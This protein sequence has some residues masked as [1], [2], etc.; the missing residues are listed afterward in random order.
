MVAGISCLVHVRTLDRKNY[1]IQKVTPLP[2]AIVNERDDV[3]LKG[4]AVCDSP[5]AGP[6]FDV[7]C[8]YYQYKLKERTRQVYRNSKGKRRVRTVW[9]TRETR[10]EATGFYLRDGEHVIHINGDDADFRDN[11][12]D[13]DTVGGWRHCLEYF[14]F[15]ADIN[16][17]GSVSEGKKSLETYA[18]IPL[19]VTTK[20]REEFVKEA[21]RNEVWWRRGGFILS[22]L[23]LT[24][25]LSFFGMIEW[26]NW[27]V[28]AFRPLSGVRFVLGAVTATVVIG[29]YWCVFKYNSMV[30]YR[31][32]VENAWYQIDVDLSMR[33]DLIPR[34]VECVKGVMAHER[35]LTEELS[36]L[37]SQAKTS[38][39]NKLNLEGKVAT[40]VDRTIARVESY[41]DLK[42]Q[43]ATFQLTR[44]L[45][46]IEEKIAHGRTIYNESVREYNN[47]IRMFPQVVIANL[48][49]F[50]EHTFFSTPEEKTQS[51][52]IDM[53]GMG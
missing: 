40:S 16:A 23:G 22:W 46:A 35:Q 12:S 49:D 45:R 9:E 14:P 50:A 47:L 42:A 36:M 51:P 10:T 25:L 7:T 21:E 4:Q 52:D 29:L 15:P 39:E 33:Y 43:G 18:N 13:Q 28:I 1:I 20:D 30:T 38:R 19:V 24:G 41:P 31:N 2:L 11:V 27:Q 5:L 8:L 6:H 53:S 26:Q 48:F 44:E 37:R 34:L 32:R 3:W 17:V